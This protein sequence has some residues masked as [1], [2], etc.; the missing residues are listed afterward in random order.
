M[1]GREE[2][3]SLLR[4]VVADHV[5]DAHAPFGADPRQPLA[6]NDVRRGDDA[7]EDDEVAVHALEQCAHGC[8][9]D[10]ARDQERL[11]L[12]AA[13]G[14]EYTERAFREHPRPH[15]DP[16]EPRGVVAEGLHRDAKRV[17]LRRLRE[18]EGMLG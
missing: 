2:L 3:T 13:P 18:R 10:P 14:R 7:V 5:V 8:D 17:A 6:E 11:G 12:R 15:R 4:A 1:A 9:P 16:A